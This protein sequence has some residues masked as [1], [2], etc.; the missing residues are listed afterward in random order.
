VS[1]TPAQRVLVVGATSTIAAHTAREYARRG[2]QLFL[3]ARNRTRLEALADEL[4]PA[5]AGLASGEFD[6]L[7]GNA[8]HVEA[9]VE[10]LGAID[11]AIVAH[12]WLPDQ[13]ETERDLTTAL[14]AL[15]TN[16]TSTVSFLI[17]LAN[18]LEGQGHGRIA[19][20]TSVA[21]ER[22]RP[23]NYT[24]GAAKRATST[25]LE[26]VR[27]RLYATGVTVHDIRL[28]PVDTPMT[29]DHPKTPLF[30][31]AQAVGRGIVRAVERGRRTTYLP[32]FWRPIMA[33]VRHLP[34]PIFQRFDFLSGR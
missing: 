27:S 22:G 2:A 20:L 29:V 12:G 4:G 8:P 11:V 13:I 6:R 30:G 19:V 26:G 15:N 18:Q 28:G 1:A 34:E 33:V 5:M 25:Y 10:A 14:R 31:D 9:A 24:Y 16:F 7:E 23:R 21:G 17:P 3:V 32:W